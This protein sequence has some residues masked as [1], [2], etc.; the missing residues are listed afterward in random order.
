MGIAGS[1]SRTDTDT[2]VDTANGPLTAARVLL[3]LVAHVAVVDTTGATGNDLAVLAGHPDGLSRAVAVEVHHRRPAG[4]A[5]ALV[6]AQPGPPE[7]RAALPAHP[8]GDLERGSVGRLLAERG[9]GHVG[10]GQAGEAHAE[11][12]KGGQATH[13]HADPFSESESTC[14]IEVE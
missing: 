14:S 10:A 3:G 11:G 1:A 7:G 5:G 6:P 2:L 4:V 9:G 13:G 12:E 8:L